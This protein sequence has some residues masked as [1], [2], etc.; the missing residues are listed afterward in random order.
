MVEVTVN[1]LRLLQPLGTPEAPH[2]SAEE[3][4]AG[5]VLTPTWFGGLDARACD[6]LWAEIYPL[7]HAYITASASR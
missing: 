6:A 1:G 2:V 5:A 7:M 4:P 3:M